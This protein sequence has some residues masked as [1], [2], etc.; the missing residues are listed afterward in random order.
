VL[1]VL[2]V[3]TLIAFTADYV[4]AALGAKKAGA[5]RLAIVG[6]A[7]GTLLGVFTGLVGLVFMPLVGAAVGEFVAQR[8][9]QRAGRVGVAT[10]IGL[11]LGTAAKVAIAFT[12][13]G[14][15]VAALVF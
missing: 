1:G 5:S 9:L 12:M 6:A 3:L 7:V 2:A 15:F 10:W 14:V 4:A 8:D 13:V 11:L